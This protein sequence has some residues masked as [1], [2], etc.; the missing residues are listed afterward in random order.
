QMARGGIFDHVGGGFA[1]YSTDARWHVPHFEKMLY[2]NALLLSLYSSAAERHPEY[3]ECA[4][5]TFDFIVREFASP[6]GGLY[7]AYDADS[8]GQEGKFYVWTYDEWTAVCEPQ[9]AERMAAAYH[10]LRTGNWEHGLNIPFRSA[11][12]EEN[13]RVFGTTTEQWRA[14]RLRSLERLYQARARRVKPGLDDKQLTAWNGMA[15]A[16]FCDFAVAVVHRRAQALEAARKI[17]VFLQNERMNNG[18]LMRTPQIPGFADDYAFAVRA[19]IRYAQV[20]GQTESWHVARDLTQNALERFFD[21]QT[22]FF[23]FTPG[24]GE[25]LVSRNYELYDNVVPSSNAVMMH[26]LLTLSKVFDHKP[27]R[28]IAQNA[29]ASMRD[30]FRRNPATYSHWGS[31]MAR[32]AFETREAVVVGTQASDAFCR[33]ESLCRDRAL[34]LHLAAPDDSIPVF[35]HRFRA[36]TTLYVCDEKGCLPPETGDVFA[37]AQKL[38]CA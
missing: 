24:D 2:D 30:D 28:Q 34:I 3:L 27:W 18:R 15:A 1:R 4:E 16:A 38:I 13:A 5:A 17:I 35:A 29:A 22:G 14:A 10:I 19:L 36:P 9:W 31:L 7:C 25:T 20:S 12:D 6:D 21:P 23:Y 33:I 26:N 8:E 37:A 32:L 11:S